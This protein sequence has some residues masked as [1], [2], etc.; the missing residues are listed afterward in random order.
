MK[1]IKYLRK[2]TFTSDKAIFER[3]MNDEI[4]L[5]QCISEFRKNNHI[6]DSVYINTLEFAMWLNGLGWIKYET[7]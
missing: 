4:N 7:N 5:E 1:W 2:S 6:P 3:W